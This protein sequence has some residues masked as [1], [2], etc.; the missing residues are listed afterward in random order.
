[1][2]VW[3]AVVCV[4]SVGRWLG[5]VSGRV[6]ELCVWILCVDGRSRYLYIVLGGYLHML[7]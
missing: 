4:E 2:C 7:Y 5:P 3:I 6:C 1:M